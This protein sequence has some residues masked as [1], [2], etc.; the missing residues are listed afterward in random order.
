MA[1]PVAASDQ[2]RAV[3]LQYE[4]GA[5]DLILVA[6]RAVLDRRSLQ[7]IAAALLGLDH[8]RGRVHD[9]PR[10]PS[11]GDAAARDRRMAELRRA[12]YAGWPDWGL[13]ES[14][15]SASVGAYRQRVQPEDLGDAASW[16]AAA[17]IVLARYNGQQT[18]AVATLAAHPSRPADAIGAY[19]GLTLIPLDCAPATSAA[20]VVRAAAAR[21][22]QPWPWYDAGL[23]DALAAECESGGAVTA[24]VLFVA[25]TAAQTGLPP[26]EYLACLAPPFPLTI[27]VEPQL[28]GALQVSYLFQECFFAAPIVAQLANVLAWVHRQIRR[29]PEITLAEI[30]L[31]DAAAQRQIAALGRPETALSVQP[32]RI[33]QAFRANVLAHPDAV[34]L[35]YER[36]RLTYRELDERANRLAH[37][38]RGC[39][40]QDGDRVGVCLERSLDLVVMLLAVLKAGAA[41]VPMDP[42]YPIDRLAYTT[43]DAQVGVVITALADFPAGE[44]VRVV[45]P[46][47]LATLSAELPAAPPV[48]ATDADDPAYVIYTSGSTGRPKGVL[49]PHRNVLSLIAATEDDFGLSAADVWTLFHSS[50]FD[51]S[52]WEIWGA[53]LTGG[54]LVVVPYWISRSPY[55]FRHLLIKERVTVLSQTPSAFAQL[56][57]AD[58][59]QPEPL[60][61]RLVI[62]GGE[63]LDTRLLLQ[64]FDHHP[65]TECRMVNMFGITETT[66][67]VTAETIT[68]AD[69]LAASRSVGRA[70]P[71][72]HL[73]VMDAEGRLLPPGVAG[74]I[75]VGG[76]GVALYYL[77][78]PDLTAERFM[79]DPYAGGRMYRSGD[80]G[81]LRP[82]GRLEHLGRVDRQVKLRGFRI[83]LDEI[84]A[85]LLQVPAVVAAAVVLRQDDPHDAAS[86]RLDAYV[87][88]DGGSAAEVR[89]HAS[90]FLPDYMVPAT[91]TE[92]SAL[93]LTANGKLDANRLPAPVVRAAAEPGLIPDDEQATADIAATLLDIWQKVLGMPVDLDDNFFD[94]GG[95]SL[96][97]V[98]IEAMMRERN[99]VEVPMREIY[100]QQ[101]VRALAALFERRRA[102]D[103]AAS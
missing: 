31:L 96:Y 64:W 9:A 63:P 27:I 56:V 68:R 87:V 91:V 60:A 97:A 15:D 71:G 80:K 16:V 103:L 14:A 44:L 46:D 90:R 57:E 17:A 38:L 29:N 40:V 51:F 55:E 83:E 5:A 47:E 10:A 78:R 65:E 67:H 35:S 73:Y 8:P 32:A 84:R 69:A 70:L 86:A 12:N 81:R 94:L 95:N 19:E 37:A 24:G 100:V 53:L 72:W 52:V 20:E 92:L 88:L 62:F 99:L 13:P 6:Q 25:D 93:P 23:A 36:A 59:V 4:R 1:R 45:D 3:L 41:Y 49:V 39:G 82:D 89:R 58:R 18:P 43:T 7:L 61:L 11:I 79:P 101:T 28:D 102:A 33:E 34:A 2:L 76:A 98:R 75:Y 50:A 21:I 22:A 66:V 85:V 30:T 54:H 48:T 26:A 42:A 77:N 74:E